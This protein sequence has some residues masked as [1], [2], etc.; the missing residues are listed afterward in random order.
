MSNRGK[1]T[2]ISGCDWFEKMKC[3]LVKASQVLSGTKSDHKALFLLET[4]LQR[5]CGNRTFR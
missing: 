2:E 4:P 5:R 1:L 3:C